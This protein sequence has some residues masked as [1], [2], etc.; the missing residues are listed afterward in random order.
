[1]I[2]RTTKELHKQVAGY[3]KDEEAKEQGLEVKKLKK[4]IKE[5][6]AIVEQYEIWERE[7]RYLHT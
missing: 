4:R 1:M 5:L 2:R 3:L 7:G 6:E